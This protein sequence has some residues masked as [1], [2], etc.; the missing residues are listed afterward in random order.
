MGKAAA[1]REPPLRLPDGLLRGLLQNAGGGVAV[2]VHL[3][4][5]AGDPGPLQL[6]HEDQRGVGVEGGEHSHPG[7]AVCDELGRE[8]AIHFPGIVRVREPGLRREGVGVEPVQQRQVHAGAHHGILG[9]VEVQIRKGLQDQAIPE[10]LHR[11]AGVFRRQSVVYA[12]DDSVLRHQIPRFCDVQLSRS[13]SGNNGS[14]DDS[15]RH[16]AISF[17]RGIPHKRKGVSDRQRSSAHRPDTHSGAFR[18]LRR[19]VRTL[20]SEPI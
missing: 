14:F 10:I 13:G 9:G 15:Q 18:R 20:A 19:D 4:R 2:H 16:A 7:G 3:A 6:F 1:F 8:L 17:L 11:S 5:I 12:P